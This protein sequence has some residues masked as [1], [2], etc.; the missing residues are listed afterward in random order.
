MRQC[1]AVTLHHP[2]LYADNVKNVKGSSNDL[3]QYATCNAAITFTDD[4]LLLGS[5]PHSHPLFVTSYT[6]EQKFKCI[7]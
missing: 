2:E 4:D 5:K 3:A 1:A 6:R 7:L